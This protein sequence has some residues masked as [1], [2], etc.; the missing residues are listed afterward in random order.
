MD[1][2]ASVYIWIIVSVYIWIIG[3]CLCDDHR[4]LLE[5]FHELNCCFKQDVLDNTVKFPTLLQRIF[6]LLDLRE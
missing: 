2:V 5:F 3:G 6:K 4:F 1:F